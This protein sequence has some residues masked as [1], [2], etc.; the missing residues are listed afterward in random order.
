MARVA[1]DLR[2]AAGRLEQGTAPYS[3]GDNLLVLSDVSIYV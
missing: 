3:V 1:Y 2:Q